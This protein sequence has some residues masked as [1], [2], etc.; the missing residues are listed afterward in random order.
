MPIRYRNR[1][2][3]RALGVALLSIVA[4]GVAMGQDDVIRIEANLVSVPISV[5]DR[6]G[7]YVANLSK[8]DFHIFENG[9]EQEITYFGTS[10]EPITVVMLLDRSGSMG[11]YMGQMATAASSFVKELRP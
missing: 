3:L 6:D 2:V 7:R 5:F 9:E 11:L 8:E 4:A 10:D 1:F